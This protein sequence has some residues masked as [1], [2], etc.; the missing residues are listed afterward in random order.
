[1]KQTRDTAW[2]Y[3]LASAV[4]LVQAL[5]GCPLGFTP[6]I[7]LTLIQTLHVWT[8][9]GGLDPRGLA[10]FPVQVRIGY[11]SWLIAGLADPTGLMHGIQLAGTSAMVLF[12]Y[13]PMA[14]MVSLLPWN[15]RQPLSLR[16]VARTF[17]QAPTAGNS[18]VPAN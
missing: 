9:E 17:L 15:R 3:W 8:R 1:M 12:G 16:L 18:R 6:V 14:R 13:C 11:L 7:V 10:A 4:L 5:S 2:W